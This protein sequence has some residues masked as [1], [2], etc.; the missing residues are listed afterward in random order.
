MILRKNIAKI[1]HFG[2]LILAYKTNAL[3]DAKWIKY[4]TGKGVIIAWSGRN[5]KMIQT[6]V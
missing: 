4:G 2:S 1:V 6:L 5:V 3:L